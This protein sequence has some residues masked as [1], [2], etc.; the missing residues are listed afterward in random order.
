MVR[1]AVPYSVDVASWRRA[2]RGADHLHGKNFFGGSGN[3]IEATA[4]SA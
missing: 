1:A 4:Q 3:A 2:L